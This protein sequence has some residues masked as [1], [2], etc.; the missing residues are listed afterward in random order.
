MLFAL[1][2]ID[3]FFKLNYIRLLKILA[4]ENLIENI[5]SLRIWL[6]QDQLFEF[7]LK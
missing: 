1:L 2:S 4:N 7:E 5:V 6:L 3:L